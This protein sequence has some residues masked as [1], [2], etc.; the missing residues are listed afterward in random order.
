MKVSRYLW[1]PEIQRNL[2]RPLPHTPCSI[3]VNNILVFW[4]LSIYNDQ[5]SRQHWEKKITR[6]EDR[7]CPRTGTPY[8]HGCLLS[9]T[10]LVFLPHLGGHFWD[11]PHFSEIA[12]LPFT[13]GS[14]LTVPSPTSSLWQQNLEPF[15]PWLTL[16]ITVST[17][18][19]SIA[20]S[21]PHFH[22]YKMLELG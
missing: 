1:M 7:L 17:R 2:C 15:L 19:K 10:T 21:A 11:W 14:T 18:P 8:K 6:G 12:G 16:A 9:G 20:N 3:K 4:I 13:N 5:W 22:E